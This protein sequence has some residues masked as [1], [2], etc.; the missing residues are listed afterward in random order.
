MT[1]VIGMAVDVAQTKV[2]V[3]SSSAAFRQQLIAGLSPQPSFAEQA[4][5]GADALMKLD[6]SVFRTLFLDCR[7]SD[8]NFQEVLRTIERRH[9]EVCVVR[10]DSNP[11]PSSEQ[12]VIAD[13]AEGRTAGPA[14]VGIPGVG[15]ARESS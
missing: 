2:L 6:G 10:A 12:S 7:L 15:D 11:S 8:L 9:P 3:A 1:V 14:P 4:T 5:G 13:A